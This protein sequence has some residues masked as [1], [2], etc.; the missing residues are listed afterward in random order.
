V[1]LKRKSPIVEYD[2]GVVQESTLLQKKIQDLCYQATVSG[3]T[4]SE[5][6][7]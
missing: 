2:E 5:V 7:A 6:G 1:A 3:Q 4:Q